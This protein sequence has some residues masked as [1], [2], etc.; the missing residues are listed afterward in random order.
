MAEILTGFVI[1][2]LGIIFMMAG[3]TALLW[4]PIV[5]ALMFWELWVFYRRWEFVE[6]LDWVLLEIRL[7]KE[8]TK[9][10]QAMEVFLNA[11]RQT[12]DGNTFEKYWKGK[13]RA[14]HSLE[15]VSINGDIHFY[16]YVQKGFKNIVESQLYAQYPGAEISEVD[17]YA[18]IV[19]SPDFWEEWN[20]WGSE[21]TLTGD[22]V[23]PIRTYIDYGL[24][25]MQVKEEFKT[26]PISSLIEFLGSLKDGEQAWLQILIKAKD[27]KAWKTEGETFIK[28]ITDKYKDE[29][30]APMKNLT[31]ADKELIEVVGKNISKFA[32][33]VVMRMV[34][35]TKKDKY[36]G[37][38]IG[39]FINSVTTPFSTGIYN[40]LKPANSTSVD[41]PP[42]KDYRLMRKK[43]AMIKAYKLRGGFYHPTFRKP[44]SLNTEALATIYHF[45]GGVVQTP[46]FGRIEAKKSEPPSSLP[47]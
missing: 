13:L 38:K 9:T 24:D 1:K 15:I 29:A 33:D 35:V 42:L 47:V 2:S 4:L 8:I 7:P 34:Y 23:L 18:K 36:D 17:D 43:A 21:P 41:Y 28:T 16:F 44:F 30:K 25:K 19:N 46:S 37:S 39:H 5:L 3:R 31:P 32:F 45:P 10:P 40:G 12:S 11:L 22:G 14:W 26:D 6:S 27:G 20:F